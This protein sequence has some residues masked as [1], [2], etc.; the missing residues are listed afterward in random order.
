MKLENNKTG[1]AMAGFM[2]IVHAVWSLMVLLGLAQPFLDFIFSV[3]LL[4]NAFVVQ[5]FSLQKAVILV[6]ITAIIGYLF[7]WVF[8]WMWNVLHK[9][10]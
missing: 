7:G 4:N 1:L 8:A 3:H 6:V 2:A 5:A 10:H 9:Q